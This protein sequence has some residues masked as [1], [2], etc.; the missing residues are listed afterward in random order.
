[1]IKEIEA[2]SM[3]STS[4]DPS[5]WFGVKYTFN[6]YRDCQHQCIYCDSRS[7]CYGIENFD[8]LIVKINSAELLRKELSSKRKKGTIGTGA[9]GDP[10][11]PAEKKYELTRKALKVISDYNYPVHLITKSN[12]VLRDIDILQEI[13]KIYASVA[14]TI[15]T[16]NDDLARKVEPFASP[17]TD[18]LKA[19]GVLSKAGIVTSITMMPILPFIEDNEE[20]IINIV[21]RAAHYGVNHIVPWLGM[22]LRDRQRAYYY[23]KLD[24]MFPGIRK[25]YEKSFGYKYS[26]SVNNYKKLSNILQEACNKYNISLKMPSYEHKLSSVQLN[27]FDKL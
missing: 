26:C 23:S 3:L 1:M 12:L 15:T 18:R 24:S 22:S 20:N 16:T 9:M 11:T 25:K 4:K 10:Y 2:K 5:R 19:L 14:I 13:N 17:A 27:L 6:S 8:D 7:E 21:N